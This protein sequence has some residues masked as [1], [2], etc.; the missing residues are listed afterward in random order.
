MVKTMSISEPLWG[1]HDRVL[2]DGNEVG[3][4]TGTT[5]NYSDG[6]FMG[7]TKDLVAGT[8]VGGDDRSIHFRTLAL[9]QGGR[10]AMPIYGKFMEKVY[11]DPDLGIT[12]AFQKT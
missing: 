12:K 2:S 5:S 6:W 4:K 10:M 9:G 3:G 7:V 8:W 11:A 1:F